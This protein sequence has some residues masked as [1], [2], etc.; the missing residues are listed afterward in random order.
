M[1][2]FFLAYPERGSQIA[3]TA[4]G[5]SEDSSGKLQ[6]PFVLSWS[7]YV[8][9]LGLTEEERGFYEIEAIH[10]GWTLRELKRQFNAGLYERLALSRD[11]QSIRDVA[12]KGTPVLWI[13]EQGD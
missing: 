10:L 12:R 4:S 3:Q 1:R 9:L 6:P 7:H 8:F 11:Q 13:N 5:Q 2:C